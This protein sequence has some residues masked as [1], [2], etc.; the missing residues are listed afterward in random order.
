MKLSDLVPNLAITVADYYYGCYDD[1]QNLGGFDSPIKVFR[2]T[3]GAQAFVLKS[4]TVSD[5]N[6]TI[7]SQGSQEG[8]VLFPSLLNANFYFILLVPSD[9]NME[10]LEVPNSV[11]VDLAEAEAEAKRLLKEFKL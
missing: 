10:N 3:S 6:K 5:I 1:V 4:D 7:F 2:K 8:K 9:L 11:F